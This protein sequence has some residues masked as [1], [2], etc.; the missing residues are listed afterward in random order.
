MPLKGPREG[1]KEKHVEPVLVPFAKR[2]CESFSLLCVNGL[3]YSPIYAPHAY[4]CANKCDT[5]VMVKRKQPLE[6]TKG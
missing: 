6:V 1:K 2:G 5:C 4:I 3:I